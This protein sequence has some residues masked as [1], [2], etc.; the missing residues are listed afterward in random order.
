MDPKHEPQN[1]TLY[2]NS[3]LDYVSKTILNVSYTNPVVWVRLEVS[4]G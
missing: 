3:T 4:Q 2:K 1:E